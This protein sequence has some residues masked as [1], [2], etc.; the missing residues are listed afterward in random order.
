MKHFKLF[1][2]AAV[3]AMA[4][5]GLVGAGSASATAL[6]TS[7]S[8]P[9]PP[10]SKITT[11]YD[12]AIKADL[13]PGTSTELRTTGFEIFETCTS[14]TLNINI[15]KAGSVMETTAGSVSTANLTWG[16]CTNTVAATEAG[17]IEIHHIVGTQKGTLTAK[18]F[19]VTILSGFG[20]SCIYTFGTGTDIGLLTPST[21]PT[22]HAI[23]EIDAVL[24]KKSGLIT[25]LN[26]VRWLAEYTVTAP[27]PLYVLSS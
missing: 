17:E 25:C 26:Q 21:S 13:R 22:T 4:L 10:N 14:S 12:N 6:C 3:A 11:A 8:S 9:C 7:S 16:G 19:G 24:T 5:L 27:K 2:L 18:G 20:G 1:G 15:T 23:M